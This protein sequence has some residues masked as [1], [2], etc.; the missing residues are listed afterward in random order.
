MPAGWFPT[1]ARHIH[2]DREIRQRSYQLLTS[3]IFMKRMRVLLLAIGFLLPAALPG[4]RAQE[5][6][7]GNFNSTFVAP[8]T[9]PVGSNQAAEPA[10][11]NSN[12]QSV[13][14]VA[15]SAGPIDSTPDIPNDGA[16][17]SAFYWD[18][19]PSTPFTTL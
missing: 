2:P 3:F 18:R 4:V 8:A 11:V 7:P 16:A 5:V 13:S 14:A 12:F 1:T 15:G 19:Y 9:V 10:T 17:I 6:Q